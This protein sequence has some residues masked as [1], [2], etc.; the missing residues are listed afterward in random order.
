LATGKDTGSGGR[1]RDLHIVHGA[2]DDGV[3]LAGG[4]HGFDAAGPDFGGEVQ[5]ADGFAEEGGFFVLG[6]GQGDS[7]LG[8]EK[9][10]GKAGKAGS[11]AKVQE[12][13]GAGSQ[14][15]GGKEAFAEV[16]TDD[17]F[18]ITDGG[19]VGAGVPL[20]EEIKVGGEPRHHIF[21]RRYG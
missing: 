1:K 8:T 14:M 7:D 2:E 20:E 4:G 19:E 6:F 9:G 16:A 17:L 12:G 18:G 15:A 10:D 21:W 13:L 5:S 11:G 3:E